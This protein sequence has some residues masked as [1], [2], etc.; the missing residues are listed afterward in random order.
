VTETG[1]FYNTPGFNDDTRT[2]L[3][4]LVVE[5]RLPKGEALEVAKCLT[6]NLP[7]KARKL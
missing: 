1:G 2:F 7:T 3:G 4:R 5:Y 6:Y